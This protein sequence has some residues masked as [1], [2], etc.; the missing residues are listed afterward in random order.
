MAN[1]RMI[2]NLICRDKR[3]NQLSSDTGR[4][5]FTW[6]ITFADREGRV[7]GDP[8]VVRSMVFPRRQDVTIEQMEEIIRE[9]SEFGLAVWYEAQGD[10]WIWFPKFDEN[11]KGLRKDREAPSKIPPPT[12][13]T[14]DQIRDTP[15]DIRQLS[16]QTPDQIPVKLREENVN[17]K[18][19]KGNPQAASASD[20][21]EEIQR[22][23]E[24][25]GIIIAGEAD[26]K[27][28]TELVNIG[29]T[30]D[31]VIAGV[32]WKAVNNNGKA[33]R[34][35]SSLIGP[36]KT[37]MAKRLQTGI[38]KPTPPPRYAEVA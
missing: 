2:T 30:V 7:P 14:P 37:A 22:A 12:G 13:Q 6:L 36:T 28:I 32:E 8:A 27:T 29:A 5:A 15:D 4:L 18:E 16:G 35:I 10:K 34:Y 9:W 33:I 20:P 23:Y 17:R 21:F 24:S 31:D 26:I 1:G 25:K 11:Q 38:G 19:E 3:V